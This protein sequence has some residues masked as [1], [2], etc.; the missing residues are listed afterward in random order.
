MRIN[1]KVITVT[2]A[3]G[4][5]LCVVLFCIVAI[6]GKIYFLAD[7]PLNFMSAFL[8]AI[9]TASITLILLV[10]QS[11]AEEERER[12][13]RVFDKKSQLYENYI[14]M[15]NKIIKK[16]P[17][18]IK[19][20]EDVESEFY[21]KLVLYLD[22]KF[23]KDIMDR[24]GEIADCVESSIND[25]FE[26]DEDKTK[27]FDKLR[28][29]LTIIINIL[30][31]DLGLNGRINIKMLMDTEKKVFF[32][33]FRATL[34][35]E[36]INCFSNEKELIVKKGFL[37]WFNNAPYIILTLHGEKSYAGEILIGPF[38]N[39][40][41]KDVY[42]AAERLHFSI[43]APQFNPV[44]DLYTLKYGNEQEN[45]FISMENKNAQNEYDEIGYIDL[46]YP[47][48]NDSFQDNELNRNM[49]N[50]F[51]PPFSINDSGDL[52]SRYHGIYL[53]VCKAIAKRTYHFF[54]KAFAV[55]HEESTQPLVLRDLCIKMGNVTEQEITDCEAEK[56][57]TIFD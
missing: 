2:I 23:H 41:M 40:G 17:I 42:L 7:L 24:F 19:D 57:G 10:G 54:R 50:D 16:Q 11:E 20:F 1:K 35:Q 13:V 34:L 9:I 36:V 4:C 27:N 53:E 3:I 29:N 51:I 48:D 38:I 56:Q 21:S 25:R 6:L 47:L 46:S 28:E 52:Y 14:E 32:K 22:K 43:R 26:K 45:R 39:R 44:A 12:N 30:V 31:E 18:K 33:I 5:L 37:A 15:L 49:Y 55:S 8:G